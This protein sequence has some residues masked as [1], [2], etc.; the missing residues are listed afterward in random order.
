MELEIPYFFDVRLKKFSR[1]MEG[2]AGRPLTLLIHFICILIML[3]S[4]IHLMNGEGISSGGPALIFLSIFWGFT[5]LFW[6]IIKAGLRDTNVQINIDSSGVEML[7]STKQ[8]NIDK[9][10]GVFMIIVFVITFKGGQWSSWQSSVKWKKVKKIVI[11][12]ANK[13]ILIK[14]APWNIRIPCPE[15]DFIAIQEF[16]VKKATSSKVILRHK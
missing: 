8:K 16:I 14:G 7:P 12:N 1:V 13:E 2:G 10:L 15:N 5:L 9:K 6:I 3:I 4:G 11:Y